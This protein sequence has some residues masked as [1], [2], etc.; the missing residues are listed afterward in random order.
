MQ[1]YPAGPP[2]RRPVSVQPRAS[3][4]GTDEEAGEGARAAET[5][6]ETEKLGSRDVHSGSR[7]PGGSPP[8][9]RP[10]VAGGRRPRPRRLPSPPQKLPPVAGLEPLSSSPV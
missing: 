10:H 8:L 7:R 2:T 9:A 6:R 3:P 1:H 4:P 5:H